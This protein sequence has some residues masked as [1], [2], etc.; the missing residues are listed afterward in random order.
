MKKTIIEMKNASKETI[1]FLMK[2]G[3]I[4]VGEDN[5]FHVV[6]N[7]KARGENE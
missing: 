4:Y 7:G 6:E 3:I 2:T 5:E 1:D